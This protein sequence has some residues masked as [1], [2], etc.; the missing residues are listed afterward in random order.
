MV[1]SCLPG[2]LRWHALRNQALFFSLENK[3][4]PLAVLKN[5]EFAAR[6]TPKRERPARPEVS[7]LVACHTDNH[8]YP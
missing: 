8:R 4:L 7:T 2:Q 5:H 1:P 6:T 3:E